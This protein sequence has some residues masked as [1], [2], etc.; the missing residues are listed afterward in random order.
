MSEPNWQNR[1]LFHGDNLDFLRAMNSESVDL[2]ATDPPFNKGRDFHATPDS[3]ASGAK[4]QDRWSWEKDVHQEWVDQIK[5]DHKPLMEAI[6]SAKHAHSDGMGAFMCFMAV[7]LLAMRRVLKPTGSLYL[8]CDPTASHYLKAVM[9]AVFGYQRFQNEIIWCYTSGGVSKQYFGKKHDIILFYT[10]TN[11][12]SFNT[13]Y[14]PYSSALLSHKLS[15]EIQPKL[16]FR[17]VRRIGWWIQKPGQGTP[18]E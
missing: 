10:K 15:A 8:H 17:L 18:V 3:L 13:Q 4:F 16:H 1:T 11:A 5:D 14:R 7:R 2:I 9:D 12:Y 6:E